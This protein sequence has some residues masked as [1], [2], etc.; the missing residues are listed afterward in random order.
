MEFA[1]SVNWQEDNDCMYDAFTLVLNVNHACNLRCTYCY[2][3]TKVHRPMPER[4]AMAAVG[5]AVA[6]VG[7]GGL[8]ELGFFGGEPLLEA[9]LITSVLVNA[10]TLCKGRQIRFSASLTTNGT[11]V[12]PEAWAVMTDPDVA[13]SISHDGL[14]GVHDRHRI[15]I[16]GRGTSAEVETTLRRLAVAERDFNVVIVV[17]PDTVDLLPG[18]VRYLRDLGARRVEP[19]IDLWTTWSPADTTRLRAAVAECAAVWRAGLPGFSMSWFDEKLV[20]IAAVPIEAGARCGFGDGQI[21][22][23]PSGNLYPC[24][25]VMGEDGPR[26]PLRLPGHVLEGGDFLSFRGA[27]GPETASCTGCP[28]ETFC[29]TTCR[30]SN[31]IRT[32]SPSKPDD[33]LCTLDQ[34]CLEETRRVMDFQKGPHA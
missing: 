9:R 25:R 30:C 5:R 32:G 31:Y 10:R 21:A 2:T 4:V 24:E 34:A 3:G 16:D 1:A 7:P 33:L 13:L 26:Q 12:G 27:A 28:G 8:L 6:S 23:A 29:G 18:G 15:A 17:R 19:S 11:C 22:V 20:R 14:P